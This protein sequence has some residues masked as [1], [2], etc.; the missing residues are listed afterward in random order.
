MHAVDSGPY[1]HANWTRLVFAYAVMCH[2]ESRRTAEVGLYV[3]RKHNQH[4]RKHGRCSRDT[5]CQRLIAF[6]FVPSQTVAI[7]GLHV[8]FTPNV[9]RYDY[10]LLPIYPTKRAHYHL[11]EQS[12]SLQTVMCS[13]KPLISGHISGN[14][15]LSTSWH[16]VPSAGHMFICSSSSSRIRRCATA[17]LQ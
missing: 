10:A 4:K 16:A 12:R 13:H 3:T 9:T 14:G 11:T 5:M 8:N 6:H 1:R 17:I 15:H 7:A 2:R